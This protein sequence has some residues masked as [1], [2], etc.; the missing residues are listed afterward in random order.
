MEEMGGGKEYQ[1][2]T[3]FI[4]NSE[5]NKVSIALILFSHCRKSLEQACSLSCLNIDI[6]QEGDIFKACFLSVDTK[7]QDT[8][9][10]L[11]QI[12]DAIQGLNVLFKK[13]TIK[14]LCLKVDIEIIVADGDEIPIPG[15][16]FPAI[17]ISLASDLEIQT[18]FHLMIESST[19]KGLIN[20]GSYLYVMSDKEI[21]VSE[22]NS[23]AGTLPSIVYRKGNKGRYTILPFNSWGIE[24]SFDNQLPDILAYALMDR[25]RSAKEIGLYCKENN[26]SSHVDLT[27]YSIP[28][29]PLHFQLDPTFFSFLKDLS[30]RYL[31]MD[32]MN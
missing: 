8:D 11:R 4:K 27:C 17:Y 20:S 31:D 21:D 30:V 23:V 19:K 32:F 3:G 15:I 7:D 13:H 6:I 1:L 12:I 5:M 26:L 25:V 18:R 14:G 16:T 28:S 24:I 29:E 10:V 2:H 22:L 9:D